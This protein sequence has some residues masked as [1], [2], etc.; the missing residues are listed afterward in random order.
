[1]DIGSAR[2]STDDQTLDLQFGALAKAGCDKVLTETASG[3][4]AITACPVSEAKAAHIACG[5]SNQLSAFALDAG[6]GRP[7]RGA[8]G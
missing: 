8:R 2:V 3:A 6:G 7:G 5:S 1:M 4:S